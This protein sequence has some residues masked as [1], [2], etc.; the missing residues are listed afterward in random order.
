MRLEIFEGD[1][2]SFVKNF[3]PYT[4]SGCYFTSKL[5]VLLLEVTNLHH[6]LFTRHV[7]LIHQLVSVGVVNGRSLMTSNAYFCAV[8][9]R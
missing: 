5:C 2:F 7:L 9:L 6:Q 1:K 3:S 4:R 8:C